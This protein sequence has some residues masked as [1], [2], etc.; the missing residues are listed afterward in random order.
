MDRKKTKKERSVMMLLATEET[1]WNKEFR[2]NCVKN[3][4]TPKNSLNTLST[5]LTDYTDKIL[6][7]ENTE[8]TE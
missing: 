7:T 5:D 6:T 4:L 3:I 1:L 8:D 2:R